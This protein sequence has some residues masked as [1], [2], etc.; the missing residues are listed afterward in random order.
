MNQKRF[1]I[2][3]EKDLLIFAINIV[4]TTIL[5][6]FGFF[7]FILYNTQDIRILGPFVTGMFFV[8]IFTAL[9]A[10]VLLAKF[11]QVYPLF[12]VAIFGAMGAVIGDILLFLFVKERLTQDLLY[13]LKETKSRSLIKVYQ[14]HTFRWLAP[15]LGALIILS[16]LPDELGVAMLGV[17]QINT[18][19]FVPLS[20]FLNFLSIL[21]L[22]FFAREL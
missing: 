1:V 3:L 10:S 20:F 12:E 8:S 13:V 2:H 9:P 18:M 11:T 4:I 7:N 16:P 19:F 15:A 22:G 5:A 6:H 21:A 17:S 14:S